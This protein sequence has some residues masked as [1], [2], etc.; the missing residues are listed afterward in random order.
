MTCLIGVIFFVASFFYPATA[1]RMTSSAG[2]QVKEW[3][4]PFNTHLRLALEPLER[5]ARIVDASVNPGRYGIDER[6]DGYE[7]FIKDNIFRFFYSIPVSFGWFAVLFSIL[8]VFILPDSRLKKRSA[9]IAGAFMT[10]IAVPLLAGDFYRHATTYKPYFHLGMSAY[11]IVLSYLLTGIG[12]LLTFRA[13]DKKERRSRDALAG[14]F[15]RTGK[16][17]FLLLMSLTIV[18]CSGQEK[19][20]TAEEV[21]KENNVSRT[22]KYESKEGGFKIDFPCEPIKT[23]LPTE[24]SY[25]N[26]AMIAFECG[27]EIARFS[28][29]FQDFTKK[30]EN[31]KQFYEEQK[32]TRVEGMEDVSKVVAEIEKNIGVFPAVYLETEQIAGE[33]FPRAALYNELQLLKGQRYYSI[34]T[35]VLAKE[36]QSPKDI[37]REIRDKTKRFID[38]FELIE[39]K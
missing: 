15:M 12:F 14:N 27:N 24:S 39:D 1:N 16:F 25:G 2:E 35:T 21:L 37:S 22:G 7:Y 34:L 10:L 31:P 19:V 3:L 20:K 28:V 11:F 13:I 29:S 4:P 17:L 33:I 32:K 18:S 9:L 30:A 5:V 26:K 8:F 23:E 6:G 36:G 38:S